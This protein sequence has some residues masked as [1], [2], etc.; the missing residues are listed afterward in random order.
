V[1]VIPSN[2][3]LADYMNRVADVTGYN[4]SICN[5]FPDDKVCVL[6]DVNF[7]CN[8]CDP[9]FTMFDDFGRKLKTSYSICD[10][11]VCNNVD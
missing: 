5:D 11:L 6:G 9:G 2:D 3:N 7:E 1:V 10:D 8:S 4:E